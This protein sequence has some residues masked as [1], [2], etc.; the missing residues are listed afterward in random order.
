MAKRQTRPVDAQIAERLNNEHRTEV[1]NA[2]LKLE[3]LRTRKADIDQRLVIVRSDLLRLK[4]EEGWRSWLVWPVLFIGAAMEWNIASLVAQTFFGQSLVALTIFTIAL[5]VGG[6]TIGWF[7]GRVLREKRMGG[8]EPSASAGRFIAATCA[9]IVVL[10]AGGFLLRFEAARTLH[11]GDL[12]VLIGQATITTVLSA[13]GILVSAGIEFFRE[14]DGRID[15]LRTQRKLESERDFLARII[16]HAEALY[17]RAVRAY[18]LVLAE[19]GLPVDPVFLAAMEERAAILNPLVVE[20]DA[21]PT[22][23]EAGAAKRKAIEVYKEDF[24]TRNGSAPAPEQ[25]GAAV[26]VGAGGPGPEPPPPAASP[27]GTPPLP[28]PPPVS[29]GEATPLV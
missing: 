8:A 20:A 6:V 18:G 7:L 4:D 26:A 5:A 9:V 1:D 11:N 27:V 29:D 10:L 15:T 22:A 24:V 12:V 25:V 16:I 23:A 28:A 3:S 2:V 13:L 21:E 17:H 14:G 19:I